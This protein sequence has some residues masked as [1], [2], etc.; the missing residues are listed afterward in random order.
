MAEN[1][2]N[3][4]TGNVRTYNAPLRRVRATTVAVEKQEYYIFR[5]CVFVALGTQHA[6]R[7]RHSHL[8]PV[9]LYN[10]FSHYLINGSIS[11]KR[12]VTAHKMCVLIFCV[13]VF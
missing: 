2:S 8:W 12:K 9:R 13:T 7:I 10:I 4:K 3:D 1:K 5:K 11:E 6:M